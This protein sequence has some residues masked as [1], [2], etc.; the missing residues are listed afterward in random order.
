MNSK[1]RVLV[2]LRMEHARE[3]DRSKCARPLTGVVLSQ[4]LGVSCDTIYTTTAQGHASC[5]SDKTFKAKLGNNGS[6]GA[7]DGDRSPMAKALVKDA[8]GSMGWAK[9]CDGLIVFF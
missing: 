9:G 4:K 5:P 3:G 7:F 2:L 6:G 1:A 8:A